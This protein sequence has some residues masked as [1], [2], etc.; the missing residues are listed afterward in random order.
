M[1]F[2][3]AAT[4]LAGR[5]EQTGLM[6]ATAMAPGTFEP[7]LVPRSLKDQAV[8]TGLATTLSYVLTVATQDSIE[9]VASTFSSRMPGDSAESRQRAAAVLLDLAVIP[10]GLVAQRALS[11][12]PGEPVV[13]GL[14]RQAAWRTTVTGIG[15]VVFALVQSGTSRLDD[16]LG[17]QGRLARFPIAVPAGLAVGWAIEA[18]RKRGLSGEPQIDDTSPVPPVEAAAAGLGVAAALSAAAYGERLVAT[19]VGALLVCWIARLQ[20]LLAAGRSRR[21]PC[22]AWRRWHR[23]FPSRDA[24][25]R[26]RGDGDRARAQGRVRA[27]LGGRDRERSNR[28]PRAVGHLGSRGPATRYRVRASPTGPRPPRGNSRPVD[29]DRDGGAGE[30]QSDPGLRGARQCADRAGTR[31]PGSR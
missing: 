15:G 28:E 9:A 31:R 24:E 13:R 29:R 21:L 16:A 17:A 12:R 23:P 3:N 18:Q 22:R 25:D 27:P 7:S 6:V 30:G 19:G 8:V 20:P 4:G 5:A 10:T 11:R 26:G 1:G 14:T 2:Q